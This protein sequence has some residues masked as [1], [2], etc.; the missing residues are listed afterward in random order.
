MITRLISCNY[1]NLCMYSTIQVPRDSYPCLESLDKFDKWYVAI[2]S[3]I[4][5]EIKL[6]REAPSPRE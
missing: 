6:P 3:R 5:M 2:E 4:K 1:N